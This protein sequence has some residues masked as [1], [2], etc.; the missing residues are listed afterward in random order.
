[1]DEHVDRGT[2]R[3]LD[4]T[5]ARG[6]RDGRSLIR[7][8]GSNVSGAVD[9]CPLGWGWLPRRRAIALVASALAALVHGL[10]PTLAEAAEPQRP[11]LAIL[12]I[13]MLDT[14]AEPIDQ[15]ADQAR[16]LKALTDA[17]TADL[18]A[19][20][21]YRTIPVSREQLRTRCPDERPECLLDAARESGADLVFIGVVHKSSTLIMQLWARMV[22]TA[23]HRKVFVRDLNFRGDND[24]AWRRAEAFLVAQF[25]DSGAPR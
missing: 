24:E 17:L 15:S 22:D 18:A 20:G 19:S 9:R 6:D 25:I 23:S 2:I 1:M 3:L 11:T 14:S 4:E 8:T 10:V 21:L 5:F 12:P 7:S 16:R 13:K